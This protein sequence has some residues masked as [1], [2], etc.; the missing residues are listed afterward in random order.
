MKKIL[1]ITKNINNGN[2]ER[3]L[4]KKSEVIHVIEDFQKQYEA[5]YSLYEDLREEVK[6]SVG[7]HGG[8]DDNDDDDSSSTDSEMYYS[9]GGSSARKSET[10]SVSD[11]SANDNQEPG[12][13]SDLENTI[14]KDKLTS[15]IEVKKTMN[16]DYS[17]SPFSRTPEY[18]VVL[19]ELRIDE[20]E[21]EDMREKLDKMK[22]LEGQVS[23]LK[24][25]ILILCSEKRQLQEQVELKSDETGHMKEIISRLEAQILEMEAS[26]KE[27]EGR[28]YS[29][30]K[31]SEDNEQQLLSRISEL[32]AQSNDLQNELVH[33]NRQKAELEV[34]L[35]KKSEEASECLLQVE[36]LRDELT[37][38][39]QRVSEE[40]EG[41]KGKVNGLESEIYYLTSKK[42]ALEEQMAEINHKAF[43]SNLE[44]EKLL[45]EV[46]ALRTA[47]SEKGNEL[48]KEQK[49]SAASHKI[50]SMKI[51]SSEDEVEALQKERNSLHLE[52]EALQKEKKQLQVELEKEREESSFNKSQAEKISGTNF[53]IVDRKVEEM[54][55][56]FRKQFEDKYR[57]LSRRIRVA[58]QLQVENKEWY[59]K[60]KESY[61]QQSKELKERAERTEAGLK[62]VKDMT[63][64]AND[65]L[66]SLDSVAL[67]F[68]ESAANFLNR[69]SKASCELKF[70]KHR[71]MR[72]N[73]ALLHVRDDLECIL[74]QLD[75]KEAEILMFRE[76]VWKSEN[77]VRELEKMIKERDDGMIVL[78]EE[79]REAIRQLCV[80][81]DYHRSRS[82]YYN[83]MLS[84]MNAGRRRAS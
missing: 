48:S 1:K 15:S 44:K 52:L 16:L 41:L 62:Y 9:P 28:F 77:K 71:A 42:S 12:T 50:M 21:S 69:I 53:Q 65:V 32:M 73:K 82:D 40:N 6:K 30:R 38:N 59:R 25:E 66:I 57:I 19:K 13:S 43:Q 49:K 4:R 80:W 31:Q 64:T 46:L 76:K 83:K 70:A 24:L 63:L 33:V 60:T 51:K 5:L 35:E 23:S 84:E 29:L 17:Q 2:K 68:E 37:L 22:D 81:I 74:R 55:E 34:K 56:E 54:A 36:V 3:N 11:V 58:E 18:G 10:S 7:G 79:K 26:S 45:K 78:K 47:L 61:E 27:K 75:D 14:L 39:E 20:D 8:D 72:K 67:R